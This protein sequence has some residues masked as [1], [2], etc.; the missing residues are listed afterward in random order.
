MHQQHTPQKVLLKQQNIVDLYNKLAWIYDFW[1]YLTESKAR[2]RALEL[3][4]I[5]SGEHLLEVAVGTGLAF[6][7]VVRI[8]PDG[9][10][11]GIDLSPGML[12]KAKH[13]LQKLG[14]S[15]FELSL[16]NASAIQENDSSFDVLLNNYMFDL[17][18]ESE[19]PRILSEFF[20]VLKPRGRLVLISMTF[21]EKWGS[22]IYERLYRISPSLMGGCRGIEL[23]NVIEQNGFT[24]Q[25]RE[26]IQ[27]LLFPSEVILA[28]KK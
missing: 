15:N 10:N 12:T 5:K 3:A 17:I 25:L 18:D 8:N 6:A 22:G 13:R 7:Q 19:W 23:S 9:R 1:G 24:V 28:T 21:G 16:G 27:Q 2:N 20:R 11:T 26:Y 4:N 14:L